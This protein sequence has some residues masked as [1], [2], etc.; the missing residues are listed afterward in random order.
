MKIPHLDA[1]RRGLIIAL[2]LLAG[3]Y[4]RTADVGAAALRGDE[5]WNA[6]LAFS[7]GHLGQRPELGVSSSAQV[8]QSPFFHDIFSI[9][10]AFDPDPRLARLFMAVLHLISMPVLYFTVRRYWSPRT[11][12]AALVLYAVMPRAIWSGRFLW[13]P[14]LTTPFV[15]GTY[16]TGF[17]ATEGKRWARWLHLPLLACMVQAHPITVVSTPIT[18]IF[19]VRDWYCTHHRST[20]RQRVTDY[21]IGSVLAVIVVLPWMIGLFHLQQSGLSS[22]A[23]V[24]LRAPNP[25]S[26]V[27][28]DFIRNPI[29]IDVG[30]AIHESDYLPP[31]APVS[32]ALLGIG[33]LTFLA[34]LFITG[35]AIYLKRFQDFVI[36]LAYL[37]PIAVY[38]VLPARVYEHYMIPLLPATAIIQAVALFGHHPRSVLWLRLAVTAVVLVSL[39][40]LGLV[41]DAFQQIRNYHNFSRDSMLSLNDMI[42]FRDQAVRPGYETIY[43]VEGSGPGAFEQLT[44]WLVLASKGPSRVLWGD[45][46]ALPVPAAGATYVGYVG[47]VHIP[48]LY[49]NREARIV[50]G[51]VYRAVDLPPDSAFTPTCLPGGP[52]RLSNGATILGYYVPSNENE[53]PRPGQPWTIYVLWEGHRQATSQGY[54]MFNHLVDQAGKHRYGQSDI[55]ALNSDLWRDGEQLVSRVTLTPANDLPST[56]PLDLRVGMYTL[57]GVLNANALDD[58]GNMVGQWIT[59]PLCQKR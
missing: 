26:Q 37:L 12:L 22:Q 11:A 32:L 20:W 7:T 41:V 23:A 56:G 42:K 8:N 44:T 5:T 47:A 33:W 53:Q 39:L 18:A 36:G 31:S 46:F 25:S 29:R 48:E 15:I 1:P 49:A 58:S 13:N 34:G 24:N 35:R 54:Q 45:Q 30:I 16:A 40:Q 57:P 28:M 43:L 9:P 51:N 27:W 10:F 59:I 4:L 14:Y 55:P 38:L 2:V 19:I 3:F 6:Y 50:A 52:T 17:L 21:G